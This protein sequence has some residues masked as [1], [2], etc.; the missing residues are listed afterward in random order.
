M[1][2]APSV[3][4][5]STASVLPSLSERGTE[6]L[7][8]SEMATHIYAPPD[9]TSGSD[10]TTG[11]ESISASATSSTGPNVSTQW[12][13][14]PQPE[15]KF[16]AISGLQKWEGRV[17]EVGES[18]FT[19]ELLPLDVIEE[20]QPLYADFELHLLEPDDVTAGDIVY[21]TA[22]MVENGRG[23]SPSKTLTVRLRRIGN[24]TSDD[25]ER[26][27]NEAREAWSQLKDFIE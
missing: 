8:Y 27:A 6:N 15:R 23:F 4:T 17:V 2:I 7:D 18:H 22:R 11:P 12:W 21:V 5:S 25:I 19:A 24:W 3:A 26:L 14:W 20:S 10:L 13:R 9:P 1:T 16:E